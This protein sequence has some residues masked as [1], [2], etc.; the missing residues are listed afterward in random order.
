MYAAA[1]VSKASW[2]SLR[3]AG[4]PEA[5]FSARACRR[6]PQASASLGQS[7]A[8]AALAPRPHP[9][10]FSTQARAA[11]DAGA[12]GRAG[13][14][15]R[16]RGQLRRRPALRCL[17]LQPAPGRPP[18]VAAAPRR[19]HKCPTA[20]GRTYALSS[21]AASATHAAT[22]ARRVA[23]PPELSCFDVISAPPLSRSHPCG[24]PH[25]RC[26]CAHAAPPE[27]SHTRLCSDTQAPCHIWQPAP[28]APA[29]R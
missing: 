7:A 28:A 11:A 16:H 9:P 19:R 5:A 2:L 15:G 21:A 10:L 29:A 6:L 4:A 22:C 1:P 18:L 27:A 8:W 13:R 20:Y 26:P 23:W 25:Q 24:H 12:D 14:A 17:R 3:P